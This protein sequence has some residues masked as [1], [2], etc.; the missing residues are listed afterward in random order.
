MNRE[1]RWVPEALDDLQHGYDWY[2]EREPGLGHQLVVEVFRAVG[3]AVGHPR[4]PKRFVHPELPEE[5]E[6]RRI[7]LRRFHEYSI[8]FVVVDETLWILAVAHAKRQPTYWTA[9]VKGVT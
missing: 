6:V 8:V 5:P 2:E 1:P 9:R 3:V 4:V 7:G